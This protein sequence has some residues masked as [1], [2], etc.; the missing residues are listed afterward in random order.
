MARPRYARSTCRGAAALVLSLALTTVAIG[1]CYDRDASGMQTR[2]RIDGSE[3][4]DRRTG[5][6]W[7]RC[8]LG[9]VWT[10]EAC[11]GDVDRL[12]LDA[13]ESAAASA[14]GGWRVP[15]GPE[16]Q[17][18]VDPSCGTPVVDPTVFPD[19]RP[20]EEGLAK[21]W[22]SEPTGMLGLYWNFDFLT[23]Q[24]D[25]NSRGIG[26]AVRFVRSAR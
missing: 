3:A 23:G 7:Q 26:L 8:S 16:L 13:A 1:A 11:S 20:T 24:A 10:G 17:S 12:G 14:G 18:L 9:A 15:S 19:I 2:F 4:T 6:V 25:G 21:Y 5:L 22:S